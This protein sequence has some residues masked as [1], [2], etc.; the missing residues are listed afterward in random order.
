MS[1]K[2]AF[3]HFMAFTVGVGFGFILASKCPP[4]PVPTAQPQ[5][6]VPES[7]IAPE[8]PKPE[9]DKSPEDT[10]SVPAK[11]EPLQE[12]KKDPVA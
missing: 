7:K 12:A 6:Q 3:S 10:K 4:T 11:I 1:A 2:S 5:E 8:T 9:A